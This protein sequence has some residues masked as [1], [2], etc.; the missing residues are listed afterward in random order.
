VTVSTTTGVAAGDCFTI[1][2]IEA[3]HHITK[4]STGQAK[5]FRVISV[6][7]GTTM[8]ISP[9]MIGANS[10]PTDAELAYKNIE[11]AS[12]SA[13]ASITFLNDTATGANPFWVRESIELLPGRYAVPADQGVAVMRGTTDQGLEV[14]MA[15]K[16]DN[17][18]FQSLYTLDVLFGVVNT[19]PEMNGVLL[20]N[21]T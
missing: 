16:F 19:N 17:S 7:S 2:G 15:K 11:V 9:P 4:E 8:T 5:T 14:V 12:T 1:D 3:V 6:D 20:F 13:T 18:T 10:S 21:Q